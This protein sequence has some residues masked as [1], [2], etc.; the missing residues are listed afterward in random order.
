[1]ASKLTYEKRPGEY[2]ILSNVRCLDDESCIL[3]ILPDNKVKSIPISRIY[4]IDWDEAESK[5]LNRMIE[6]VTRT[7]DEEDKPLKKEK[8]NSME[9]A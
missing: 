4:E 9:I 6:E 3:V 7:Q 1:M 2:A 5:R 8:D